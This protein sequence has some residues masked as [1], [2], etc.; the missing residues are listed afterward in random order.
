MPSRWPRTIARLRNADS[1]STSVRSSE[2][3]YQLTSIRSRPTYRQLRRH[4][5]F[6]LDPEIDEQNNKSES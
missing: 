1:F 2:P 4:Y 5:A 6:L 3:F